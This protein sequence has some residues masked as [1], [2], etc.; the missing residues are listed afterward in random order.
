MNWST[1]EQDDSHFDQVFW[2]K[3]RSEAFRLPM[4]EL[5]RHAHVSIDNRHKCRN[6]FTCACAAELYDRLRSGRKD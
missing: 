1:I 6:C 5:R 4:K 2:D 3:A